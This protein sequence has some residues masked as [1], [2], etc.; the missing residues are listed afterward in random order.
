M[1]A[2]LAARTLAVP[3]ATVAANAAIGDSARRVVVIGVTRGRRA[4]MYR[5]PSFSH[6]AIDDE[7][8]SWS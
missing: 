8:R 4:S 5:T 3:A 6:D 7:T 1:A 2:E